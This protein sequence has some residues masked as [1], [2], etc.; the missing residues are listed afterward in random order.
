M[1]AENKTQ[2]TKQSPAAFINS[3]EDAQQ[4]ADAKKVAA[5]MRK[6]TGAR[7][8]CGVVLWSA[9]VNITISTPAV[10]RVITC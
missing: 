3:I 7:A 8:K 4:R 10:E 1:V 6:A 2:P 9:T 5:M